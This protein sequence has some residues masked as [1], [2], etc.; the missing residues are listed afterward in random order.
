MINALR[1]IVHLSN[2]PKTGTRE[3]YSG[4]EGR[5]T[6]CATKMKNRQMMVFPKAYK[7]INYA[8]RKGQARNVIS[9]RTNE[10]HASS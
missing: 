7:H 6:S 2:K 3:I 8:K 5:S 4:L 1:E 9:D 10:E